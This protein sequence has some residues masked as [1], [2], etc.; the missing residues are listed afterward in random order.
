MKSLRVD[1]AE[2]TVYRKGARIFWWEIQ[3]HESTSSEDASDTRV[4]YRESTNH[5]YLV[6]EIGRVD[7]DQR[8]RISD[9]RKLEERQGGEPLDWQPA[10]H[11]IKNPETLECLNKFVDHAEEEQRDRDKQ[12][13]REQESK[14]EKVATH[15]PGEREG[16]ASGR[17]D[18]NSESAEVPKS[19]P[20]KSSKQRSSVSFALKSETS[21]YILNIHVAPSKK[22][23]D[24]YNF[25]IH[26]GSKFLGYVEVPAKRVRELGR[27]IV[28]LGK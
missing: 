9:I 23:R 12:K 20:T 16:Q 8:L 2:K 11:R 24:L 27:R 26:L 22:H 1:L 5:G 25:S 10:E 14:K 4:W 13:R 28:L 21:D 15:A 19:A 17:S 18:G 7:D 3:H 6:D